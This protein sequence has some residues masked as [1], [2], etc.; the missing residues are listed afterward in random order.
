MGYLD[1]MVAWYDMSTIN[2]VNLAPATYGTLNGTGTGIVAS[3]DIVQS[4]LGYGTRYNGTDEKTDFGDIGLIRA[5]SLWVNPDTTTE[6]L[7]LVDTGKD[8]MVSG[9]TVTYTGLTATA[10]YVDGEAGTTLVAGILQHLVC[11][12]N[13]DVDANN[14]ELAN[15]GTNFGAVLLD[16]LMVFDEVLTNLNAADIFFRQK[17]GRL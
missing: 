3:T 13:A 16:E 9:G 8:V 5:V 6:E 2:P 1:S 11:V 7:F 17:T 14:F 12:F 10:T 15:D 4:G